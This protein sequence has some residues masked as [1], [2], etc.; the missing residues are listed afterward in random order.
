MRIILAKQIE[1]LNN[2]YW[3]GLDE[4]NSFPYN[5]NAQFCEIDLLLLEVIFEA[6]YKCI[7][8]SNYTFLFNSNLEKKYLE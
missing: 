4:I 6:E 1:F 5:N 2:N 8:S 3:T 7:V